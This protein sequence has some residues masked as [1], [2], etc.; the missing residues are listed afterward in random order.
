MM[1][2]SSSVWSAL[3]SDPLFLS[4]GHAGECNI[5]SVSQTLPGPIDNSMM[6]PPDLPECTSVP[7]SL[8]DPLSVNAP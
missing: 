3:C 2:S 1:F 4:E 6:L 8:A 7:G 5:D